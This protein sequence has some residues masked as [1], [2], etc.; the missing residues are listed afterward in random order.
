MPEQVRAYDRRRYAA[1]V[2]ADPGAVRAESRARAIRSYGL[3]LVGWCALLT[4]Q[5]HRC[6]ICRIDDP[7]RRWHTD[8]DHAA[9]KHAVRGILCTCCN[10]GLGQFLDN[11]ELLSAAAN[12][13]ENAQRRYT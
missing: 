5:D 4:F 3:T 10:M 12:Y 11:P 9:S 13:L 2:L 8:H 6:A 7:N 1:E